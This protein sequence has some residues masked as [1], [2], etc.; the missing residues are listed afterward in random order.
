MT[1]EEAIEVL[2]KFAHHSHSEVIEYPREVAI[3][4]LEMAIK[5]LEYPEQN[6]VAVVPCG[7]TVSREAVKKLHC[8][9]CMDN[10]ICYRNKENCED[11]KLFDKL[12]SV[13]PERQKGEWIIL[14]VYD[15]S[16]CH[17]K[18]S[19]LSNFCPNCGADMRGGE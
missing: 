3:E 18:S 6:V 7:D 16:I 1:R 5:A 15:C 12:P 17:C 13:Q 8:D 14:D 11:L 19:I 10:N 4:A 2:D 9:I